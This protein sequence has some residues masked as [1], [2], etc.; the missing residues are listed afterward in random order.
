MQTLNSFNDVL[1][2]VNE[3]DYDFLGIG[4]LK[5]FIFG[6]PNIEKGKLCKIDD[7]S[8]FAI[9][10]KEVISDSL[11]TSNKQTSGMRMRFWTDAKKLVIKCILSRKYPYQKMNLYCSSGFDFFCSSDGRRY[12]HMTVAAPFDS[13]NGFAYVLNIPTPRYIEIDFP[14]F[15]A[16]E[17][18]AIGIP[19]GSMLKPALDYL[20]SKPIVFYGNSCTQGASASRSGN[21]YPNIISRNMNVDIM[22]YSFNASCRGE[23][24]AAQELVKHDALAY[25]IDYQRNARSIQEFCR[26]FELFYM[27]IRA[28][29]PNVPIILIGALKGPLYDKH[30]QEVYNRAKLRDELTYYINLE[31][32]FKDIDT[33]ALTVDNIHYT[34]IGMFR[35]ADTICRYLKDIIN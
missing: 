18:F 11:I 32:I 22:N 15:N 4:E 13:T 35:I 20:S 14:C 24:A 21:A 12:N 5:E 17:N 31:E 29:K 1:T 26:R 27:F 2:I 7:L 6:A 16:V 9:D 8:Q 19:K 28:L 23:I 34:D 10:N 30:I 33:I 3:I 25:V